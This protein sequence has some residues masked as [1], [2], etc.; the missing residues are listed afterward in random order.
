MGEE[1]D[2]WPKELEALRK[3]MALGATMIDTAEMY[4]EGRAESLAGKAIAGAKREEVLLVSK[5]YPFNAGKGRIFSS[6][7]ASLGRLG[8]GFLDLYL[9]H[10]RGSVPLKETVQCMEELVKRGK[11]KRWGVSN[12][13]VSDMEELWRLPGGEN[14]AVDQVLYHL[15]SRG[16]EHSLMPALKRQ[17]AGM[18]AYCP[19]GGTAWGARKAIASSKAILAVCE[20]HGVTVSQLM[21]AFALR[22][23]NVAAIP[24][25]S[26]ASHAK[27]NAKAAELELPLEDWELVGREF[28]APGRKVPLDIE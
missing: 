6:C 17:G 21:L 20:K 8:T 27:E 10:W 25:A 12:F 19:L 2:S 1:P 16:V 13:D 9:L 11:I 5:V 15:G 23:P 24:K 14:C 28:P 26:S 4:G 22:Q 18:M 7:D 3:G